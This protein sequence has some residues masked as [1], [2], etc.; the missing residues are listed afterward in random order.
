MR[1]IIGYLVGIHNK[2]IC[3]E[4]DQVVTGQMI[5]SGGKDS[6]ENYL[7]LNEASNE[8]PAVKFEHL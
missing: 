7:L 3:I 8:E 6:K 4:I 2:F 5:A 1:G